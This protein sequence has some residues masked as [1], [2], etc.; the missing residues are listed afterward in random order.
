M[1]GSRF[2]DKVYKFMPDLPEPRHKY[3]Q[4]PKLVEYLTRPTI[5]YTGSGKAGDS[6]VDDVA[7][8]IAFLDA[9]GEFDDRE[10]RYEGL[11][12]IKHSLGDCD[13]ALVVAREILHQ[14]TPEAKFA[15]T[16]KGIATTQEQKPGVKLLTIS[17]MIKRAKELG[18]SRGVRP[19]KDIVFKGIVEQLAKNAGATLP[20]RVPLAHGQQAVV[21]LGRPILRAF[22][23]THGE[24]KPASDAPALPDVVGNDD[25]FFADVNSAVAVMVGAAER[26]PYNF[27]ITDTVDVLA[28][29]EA[30]HAETF[31]LVVARIRAAGCTLAEER[32]TVARNKLE[33]AVKR[34]CRNAGGWRCDIKNK[35]DPKQADNVAALLNHADVEV[36]FN[37]WTQRMDVRWPGENLRRFQDHDLHELR[38]IASADY[39]YHVDKTLLRDTLDALAR[40]ACYDPVLDMID[41]LTWDGALRLHLW[42]ST[43]CHVPQ[44]AYHEAVGKILIG[45]MIKR[46]RHAGVKHDFV[47]VLTGPQRKGKSTMCEILTLNPEWFI[48]NLDLNA[49]PQDLIPKMEGKWVIELAEF[50]GI[51]G[52]KDAAHLKAFVST[53]NDNFTRKYAAYANDQH[54]R[55]IFIATAND[56]TPLVDATGNTRYFPVR[57][58]QDLDLEW[59]RINVEQ[60]IAEA[61]H[62]EAQGETFALPPELY[63]PTAAK[64]E[65]A[66]AQPEHEVLLRRWFARGEPHPS[67]PPAVAAL[68]GQPDEFVLTADLYELLRNKLRRPVYPNAVGAEVNAVNDA[69]SSATPSHFALKSV[70][71]FF[72]TAGAV[73]ANAGAAKARTTMLVMRA[74]K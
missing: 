30:A 47:P 61:A 72:T 62:L 52:K 63:A 5:A 27:K 56:Y 31:K 39:E 20:G 33:A 16:W 48:D 22:L 40:K 32:L 19:S 10:S 11:C 51:T 23:E 34:A 46:A 68:M 29:I 37:Q 7:E 55:C 15:E 69:V 70:L 45:G 1:P 3:P 18:Y 49:K 57:C 59:L 71:M 73:C 74:T 67:I 12:A 60:L 50:D 13:N 24:G 58:D 64:Q 21:D 17:T 25:P 42:L 44:D 14:D 35:P 4:N 66:R 8:L 36:K 2:G 41:G 26:A 43:V 54:R 9:K 53:K 38:R 65:G 28:V 6:D